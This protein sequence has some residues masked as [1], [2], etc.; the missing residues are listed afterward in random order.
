MYQIMLII[1]KFVIYLTIICL[2]SVGRTLFFIGSE[3]TISTKFTLAT[4]IFKN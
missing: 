1:D 3:F 2:A 4:L